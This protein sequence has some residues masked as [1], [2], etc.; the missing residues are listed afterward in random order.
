LQPLFDGVLFL[1]SG[2]SPNNPVIQRKEVRDQEKGG[3]QKK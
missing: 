3:K 1:G 2:Y